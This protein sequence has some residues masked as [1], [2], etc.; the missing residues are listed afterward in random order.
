MSG[1]QENKHGG[2]RLAMSKTKCEEE[3][4]KEMKTKLEELASTDR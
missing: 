4:T 2:I 1:R 3:A